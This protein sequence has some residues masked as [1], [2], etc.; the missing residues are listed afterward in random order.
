MKCVKQS[1]LFKNDCPTYTVNLDKPARERWNHVVPDF[2]DKIPLATKLADEMMGQ[3]IQST[4]VPLLTVACK[5]GTALYSEEIRGIAEQTEISAGKVLLL[6]LAYEAFAACTSV[7]VNGPRHPIHIRT[8][9]WDLPELKALTIN[10]IFKKRGRVIFRGT[11]W[12]GYIGILTGMKP[13]AFSVSINYRSTPKSSTDP[14]KAFANNVYRCISGCWPIGYL[15]REVLSSQKTYDDALREFKNAELISPTYITICGTKK[16]EGAIITRNRSPKDTFCGNI[17]TSLEDGHLIQANMDHCRDKYFTE[18][19]ETKADWEDIMESRCRYK[20]V[21]H[22]LRLM[23][24]VYNNKN[25]GLMMATDPCYSTNL[26]IYTSLMIPALKS[27]KTWTK[28]PRGARKLGK[29]QF[30]SAVCAARKK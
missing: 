8:M 17:V 11:T 22:A 5:T 19:G 24:G 3:V 7:V 25:L 23:D 10:V 20:Y 29:T 6:Q 14:V 2:K 12:A 13:R 18:T 30:K 1:N 4:L 26:T 15:V 28:L 16:N 9:D 21:A 27:M